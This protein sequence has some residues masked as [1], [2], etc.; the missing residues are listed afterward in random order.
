LAIGEGRFAEEPTPTQ[1]ICDGSLIM[2]L[3]TLAPLAFFAFASRSW[4]QG[5]IITPVLLLL[6]S[7]TASDTL[8]QTRVWIATDDVWTDAVNW[9]PAMVPTSTS[10][11]EINNGGTSSLE[12]AN[13]GQARDI[14]LG[15][16]LLSDGALSITS[17]GQLSSRQVWIGNEGG[18]GALV[19]GVGSTWTSSSTL[20]VGNSSD[21]AKQ[22]ELNIAEGGSMTA[23]SAVVGGVNNSRGSIFVNGSSLQLGSF[24]IGERGTGT[25]LANASTIQSGAVS[26]GKFADPDPVKDYGEAIVNGGTWTITNQSIFVGD[27]GKGKLRLNSGTINSSTAYIGRQASADGDAIV[28]GGTWDISDSLKVGESGKGTLRVENQGTV[29]TTSTGGYSWIGSVAGAATADGEVVI[30]NSKWINSG[31]LIVASNGDLIIENVAELSVNGISAGG[32]DPFRPTTEIDGASLNSR[33]T[34]S[35]TNSTWTNAGLFMVGDVGFGKLTIGQNATVTNPKAVLALF[36]TADAEVEVNGGTW[37]NTGRLTVGAGGKAL[38]TIKNG[39][40]VKS[41]TSIIADDASSTATVLVDGA[42]SRWQNTGTLSVGDTN[43]PGTLGTLIVRNGGEVASTGSIGVLGKGVLAGN[44]TITGNVSNTFTGAPGYVDELTGDNVPG[45]LQIV[46]NYLQVG[47]TLK[48]DLGSAGFDKLDIDGHLSILGFMSCEL[49]VSLIGNYLPAIGDS[50]DI[51]DWTT[52]D[53]SFGT[54]RVFAPTLPSLAGGRVWDLSQLY[55]SGVIKVAGTSTVPGDFNGNG[56]VDAADYVVLRDDANSTQ[57][58]F[59]LWR[60]NF[61]SNGSAGAAT[62]QAVVPE[63][64]TCV[65]LHLAGLATILIFRARSFTPPRRRRQ[66][67]QPNRLR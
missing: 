44:G 46:G 47:G 41:N 19:N 34:A 16:T 25:L 27:S 43:G 18:G 67:Q 66:W 7:F 57:T 36:S 42:G 23:S 54:T 35:I 65:L 30:N 5:A 64:A 37:D 32:G 1:N 53:S 6:A 2:P 3:R 20:T 17:G 21:S 12:N 33:A 48:F 22:G 29:K 58:Q 61:G 56:F 26:I 13:I 59:N 39:G 14:Y 55:T 31:F 4:R 11:V 40:L 45:T 9:S 60:G 50:F 15:R 49:E 63:P 38:L 51:L 28:S 52:T 24:T 10:D 8:G 62:S